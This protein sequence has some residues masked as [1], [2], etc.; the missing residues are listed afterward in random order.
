MLSHDAH[1]LYGLEDSAKLESTIDRL[2][3]HLEQLQV[4]DP[5]EEAE[6]PKK[7]LFLSKAN[8][9][10]FVNAFFDNSNHSNCFV[11]KGSFNV[12]TASTQLLLAILLL[13]ATCISP[14][15][16]ATA[17]KFSERFE[18]SVFESPEFQRLLY[19]ENHP[20][21]SRENIQLVQ[22]AMLTIVLRPSTGQLETERRIR[23]QR[24]PALVSAVRLL[25][26][27]QVLNDTVLDGEKANLDEYIR[28]ETLVR[29]MA[30][31][32]LL[33]AHCVIFSNSPPQ[34]KIAE[35]DFGLPRHDMIF[36]TTGLPDL[37]E[38][39]SN[40]DLQGPPLSL[41][42]VVQR[43]MDGKPAGIEE[44]LPQVD[45]LFALFLVLSGK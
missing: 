35:A 32:Y 10:R 17:E 16:A 36:K 24:V 39:I 8:I 41:R 44:L 27:T 9:I 29:I 40:A 19:Q 31:V 43:L 14:E 13:G 30:W 4:S 3:I 15:D 28:R 45:S 26:L 7:E 2:T 1:L 23:I 33:D 25:N 22:A 18:Y 20:T 11:Y 34:F 37:N 21:P 5:M 38:L 42:S 6:L 12:N